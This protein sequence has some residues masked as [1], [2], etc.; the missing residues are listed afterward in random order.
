M[1]QGGRG[2]GGA[3][4]DG[5]VKHTDE[6]VKH[7]AVFSPL[8]AVNC[9]CSRSEHPAERCWKL[10]GCLAFMDINSSQ[11]LMESVEI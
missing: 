11:K 3:V 4:M 6:S 9:L 8:K 1:F 2:R 7:T 10:A 5:R